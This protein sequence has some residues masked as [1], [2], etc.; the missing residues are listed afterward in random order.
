MKRI[1]FITMFLCIVLH[2]QISYAEPNNLK[3][4]MGLGLT[5]IYN[6]M[7]MLQIVADRFHSHNESVEKMELYSFNLS[8]S[9]TY[10]LRIAYPIN[11]R[12]SFVSS[13]GVNTLSVEYYNP[14]SNQIISN[15]NTY[16]YDILIGERYTFATKAGFYIQTLVGVA[17]HGE[18]QYWNR[19]ALI[20]DDGR[21]LG[22]PIWLGY[23][24]GIGLSFDI[25]SH[26]YGIFDWGIG[27]EHYNALLGGRLGIG[28]KL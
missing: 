9:P 22:L 13:F 4:D 16:A 18:A 7:G 5:S 19:Y 17:R 11:E 23:Q 1:S 8:I 6:P 21:I 14:Y 15:E 26:F 3:L 2:A 24:V 28:I 27:T 20:R 10:S 25:G 12:V